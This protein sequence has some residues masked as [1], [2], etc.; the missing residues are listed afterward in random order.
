MA[1]K[2]K[3]PEK[4]SEEPRIKINEKDQYTAKKDEPETPF[5]EEASNFEMSGEKEKVDELK[6]SEFTS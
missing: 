4:D 1:T 6:S 5:I 2:I 3:S